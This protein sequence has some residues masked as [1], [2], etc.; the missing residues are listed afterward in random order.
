[1]Q[2]KLKSTR[3]VMSRE[4]VPRTSVL[5]YFGRRGEQQWQKK[6]HVTGVF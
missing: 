3:V 4:R 1:M 2:V 6:K 5:R